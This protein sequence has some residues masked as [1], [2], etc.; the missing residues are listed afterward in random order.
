M[1]NEDCQTS[2][3]IQFIEEKLDEF[4]KYDTDRKLQELFKGNLRHC[5]LFAQFIHLSGR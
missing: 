4:C 2:D 1:I 3:A 5:V